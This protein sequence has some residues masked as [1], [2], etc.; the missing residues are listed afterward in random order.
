MLAQ[1]HDGLQ[2]DHGRDCRRLDL[3]L[4]DADQSGMFVHE[5]H[6]PGL[7]LERQGCLHGLAMP[8]AHHV[9]GRKHY[10]RQFGQ[11]TVDFLMPICWYAATVCWRVRK[12]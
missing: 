3:D 7:G 4:G 5:P 9:V 11:Q 8:G 10:L 12:P 1:D 6:R 2:S